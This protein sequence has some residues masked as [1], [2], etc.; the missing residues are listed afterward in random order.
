M[1]RKQV[2]EFGFPTAENFFPGIG[3]KAGWSSSSDQ[4]GT[5]P[6]PHPTQTSSHCKKAGRV[7]PMVGS[8]RVEFPNGW[9]FFGRFF[10]SLDSLKRFSD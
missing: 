8:L 10:Q 3:E 2:Q 9:N 6:E 1:T 7:F 4:L 5:R